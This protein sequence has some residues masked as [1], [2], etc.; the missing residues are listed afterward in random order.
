MRATLHTSVPS[1][2]A[3]GKG[4]GGIGMFA[5][6]VKMPPS[7]ELQGL[8][9]H[10]PPTQSYGTLC[11]ENEE[12]FI[13]SAEYLRSYKM[14]YL[15]NQKSLKVY[16]LSIGLVPISLRA[17]LMPMRGATI[18]QKIRL[19]TQDERERTATAKRTT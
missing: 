2:S 8:G 9:N 17:R 13:I 11:C 16:R 5:T 6:A 15:L 18:S 1:R 3:C 14:F 12:L 4:R 19:E 7:D 10:V